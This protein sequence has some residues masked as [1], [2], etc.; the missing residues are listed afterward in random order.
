M[1]PTPTLAPHSAPAPQASPNPYTSAPDRNR[2]PETLHFEPEP[3]NPRTAPALAPH[4][5]PVPLA[6]PH[7]PRNHT[8]EQHQ[9]SQEFR[10]R[11]FHGPRNTPRA[12]THQKNTSSRA[13][14][15]QN[16]TNTGST[17]DARATT[18][19]ELAL[20]RGRERGR[21]GGREREREREG[22]RERRE[23]GGT[24]RGDRAPRSVRRPLI[25]Y[26]PFN[27]LFASCH[28]VRVVHVP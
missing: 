28:S 18:F 14:T 12:T 4:S 23:R 7:I 21:E 17:F 8:P 1:K 27:R 6:Q 2:N 26:S 24:P 11:S 15:H 22:G 16:S 5:T 20:D 3:R 19:P 25:D 10:F 9:H 13:T